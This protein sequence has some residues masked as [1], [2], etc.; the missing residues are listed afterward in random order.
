MP[1]MELLQTLHG[2]ATFS[3][4]TSLAMTNVTKA[5]SETDTCAG[6]DLVVFEVP[7]HTSKYHSTHKTARPTHA[8]CVKESRRNIG[9]MSSHISPKLIRRLSL[10]QCHGRRIYYHSPSWG[11]TGTVMT[12]PYSEMHVS[13]I[14]HSAADTFQHVSPRLCLQRASTV[15]ILALLVYQTWEA[16]AEDRSA[17]ACRIWHLT[18]ANNVQ[19]SERWGIESVRTG[20]Q[21]AAYDL[22]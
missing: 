3:T 18:T 20:Q 5:T 13:G 2:H 21:L 4:H 17:Y 22:K 12:Q 14:Q 1:V 16:P 6:C 8:P 11:R 15:G 10:E 9:S 19:K 7:L